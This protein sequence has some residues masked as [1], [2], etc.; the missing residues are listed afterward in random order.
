M[1]FVVLI[2]G[3]NNNEDG[4]PYSSIDRICALQA[5]GEGGKGRQGGEVEI[6]KPRKPEAFFSNSVQ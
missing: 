3:Y 6:K 1:T 4:N 2:T 5:H